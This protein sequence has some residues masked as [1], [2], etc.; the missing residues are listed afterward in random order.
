MAIVL[1][2]TGG[3]EVTEPLVYAVFATLCKPLQRMNY[4]SYLEQE[5]GSSPLPVALA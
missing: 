1:D 2:S 5:S 4:H 3:E